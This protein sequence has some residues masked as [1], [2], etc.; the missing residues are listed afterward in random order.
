[1]DGSCIRRR[2][3]RRCLIPMSNVYGSLVPSSRDDP[4]DRATLREKHGDC[5]TAQ[6]TESINGARARR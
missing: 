3:A 2:A 5:D 1:M 6:D 4:D